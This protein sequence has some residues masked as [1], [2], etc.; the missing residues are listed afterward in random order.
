MIDLSSHIDCFE[1]VDKQDKI[2]V[3]K[4]EQSPSKHI[5]NNNSGFTISKIKI[6]N[7]VFKTNDGIK[8]DYVLK[9]FKD[10]NIDYLYLIELK[11]KQVL[12]A[13]AQID[14]TLNKLNITNQSAKKVFGRIVP[15]GTYGPDT[16]SKEFKKLDAKF[17]DMNGNLKCQTKNEDTI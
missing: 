13:V 14:K 16:R 4:D 1:I 7:C 9:V 11:G 2:I 8:C 17:R 15:I 5:L 12:K 6:D 3:S 10:E